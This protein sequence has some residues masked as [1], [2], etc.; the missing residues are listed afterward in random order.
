MEREQP[1]GST[2]AKL[3][4]QKDLT[5]QQASRMI[6]QQNRYTR[7]CKV[8]HYLRQENKMSALEEQRLALKTLHEA[9]QALKDLGFITDEEEASE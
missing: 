4:G 9:I 3:Y 6:T 8:T 1:L 7:S 2:I 5:A